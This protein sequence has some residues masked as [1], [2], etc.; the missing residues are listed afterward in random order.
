MAGSR[1]IAYI[2]NFS[3]KKLG[4]GEN[5]LA[6]LARESQSR[7]HRITF[8][9]HAPI[10]PDIRSQIEAAGATLADLGE[11][12]RAGLASV[13]A[14]S[15]E[16]D[17]IVLN[18]IAPRSRI[19]L[20]AY[21]AWPTAVLFVDHV[22]GPHDEPDYTRRSFMR[23]LVDRLTMLRVKQVAGVSNYVEQRLQARFSLPPA[24][25][26]TLY[27]G[28]D[29]QR[30]RPR[31]TRTV[32]EVV[33][34]TVVAALIPEKGVDVLLQAVA[35]GF[36]R[37]WR[38]LVVGDGPDLQRLQALSAELGL[39]DKVTFLGLRNDADDIL[40]ET[41]IF[42]HP[43]TWKEALGYTILEGMASGCA[44][45]A[46]DTGAI[47]EL[48]EDGSTGVL[49]EPG[50][51]AQLRDNLAVL[52]ADDSLREKFAQQARRHIERN[53]DLQDNVATMFDWYESI[54]L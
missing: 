9:C 20:L 15:R 11:L 45:V 44:V 17:I 41:D 14:L 50:S 26:V 4:T 37:P 10:H 6:L 2:A 13:R 18:M 31:E 54:P 24:S 39:E 30:F 36:T 35:P 28:V 29:T 7:G 5:R 21:A 48:I 46:S 3:P 43:A 34:I 38:V 19:A 25:T 49:F 23:R 32:S 33:T 47:P 51:A 16:Y 53:F 42:V 22:S 52:V 40:R 12:S 8:F 1:R 27:G